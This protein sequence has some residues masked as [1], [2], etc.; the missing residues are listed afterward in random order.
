[1][2]AS[3]SRTTASPARSRPTSS[4]R[5]NGGWEDLCDRLDV[6]YR[7][8]GALMIAV[9]E[10]EE[11]KWA[12]IVAEV[13]DCGVRAELVDGRRAQA[14]EPMITPAC[15]AAIHL[16]DGIIDPMRLTVSLASL[17]AANG[18]DVRRGTPATG[19]HPDGEGLTRID[20]ASAALSARFVVTPPVPRPAK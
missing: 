20:T 19:L 18:C 7:R 4:N 5:S 9:D 8:I 13:R 12:E 1:M 3:P 16:P 14:I 2:P 11:A 17:A 10:A 6:P 15:R